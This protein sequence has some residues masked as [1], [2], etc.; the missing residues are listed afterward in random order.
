MKFFHRLRTHFRKQELDQELSEELAFHIE[1]E[2]EENIAAGMSAEEAR[3]AALRKFGGVEQVKEECRDAWG[4]RFIDTLIQDIRFGLRMLAK[5]PGFTAVAV[6]TLALGIGANTAIFT[7]VNA[8][9]LRNLPVKNP[10]QLVLFYDGVD[11]GTHNS[12]KVPDNAYSYQAWIYFRDHNESFEDLCAFRQG[13]DRLIMLGGGASEPAHR[14]EVR[15]KL[16]AGNY[17]T[18]LG[19][20]A[21]AGRLLTAQDDTPNASPGAV[22]SYDFWRRRFNLARSVI[23]K[24]VDLNGVVFTVLGVTPPEFFGERVG[25]PPDYWLPLSWQPQVLQRESW[26]A[27]QDVY[28]LN[29][30]GRLK[31]GVSI[32]SAQA[33]VNTQLHS[34]YMMQAGSRITPEQQRQIQGVHIQLRPGGRGISVLR[35]V[36][37]EPLHVLMAVVVL[38]LLIA[39]A[40]VATL[41]LGRASAR[42]SEL[43]VRS[44]L[45]AGRSRLVRQLLTESTLLALFGA[46][47]GAALAWLGVHLLVATLP[48]ASIVKTKPDLPVLAFTLAISVL[49]GVLFGLIPAVRSSKMG[50]AGGPSATLAGSMGRST[51]KPTYTLV[52]LQVALSSV[53]LVGAAL[54]THS[55]LDLEHQDLGF[56]SDN[57]LLV[58]AGFQFAG[59]PQAQ[60]L[61]L[62]QQIQV[63][64]NALPGVTAASMARFS[65]VSG[66]I[67][68]SNFSLEGYEPPAG[69]EIDVYE[70]PV[71]PRFFETLGIPI[72]LG[73][74]IGPQDTPTS[75]LVAMVNQTFTHEYL[76]GQNPIGHH[77]S[78]GAPF[79]APGAEIIGVVADSKYYNLREKPK[80]M[81]FFPLWQA[82][83]DKHVDPNAGVL[84]IRV[85]REPSGAI[86]AVRRA[87]AEIDSGL[88][89]EGVQTLHEQIYESIDQERMVTRS[90]SFF[91][92]LALTLACI[93]LYGTMTYFVARKTKEIGIRMALGAPRSRILWMFLRDSV[94]LVVLGLAVGLPLAMGATRWIRSLLFGLPAI[95]WMAIGGTVGLMVAV[96]AVAA[97]LP[98]RRATKVDPM[99]ALR[100]E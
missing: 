29:L 97:Y 85:S 37:S 92:L 89:I 88:P 32:E 91:G 62:Y 24:T 34:Y 18:V 70:L 94:A 30:M 79:K 23:G 63:R 35:F 98:A 22:I 26:L 87:L 93:G 83:A 36:Y 9:M 44:A 68:Y 56:N 61:P 66:N 42:R 100:Y 46:V 11:T 6:L 51:L 3:Y 77:I 78:I 21:A 80:P 59:V 69:K 10:S 73:R 81:A 33:T 53:L 39:C 8:V 19:V 48:L 28:W 43:F 64:L 27:S 54:L 67:S 82:G 7:I 57:V 15:G 41:M 95:D 58:R 17:F 25:M 55:L 99:V 1:Q 52:A 49:T 31:P 90:C 74:P 38:V 45:G 84:I 5:N 75:P 40:N 12:N 65:P 4:V 47:A 2:T 50:L 71:G 60:L 96:S 86:A 16:V 72:L 14:E 76:S 13:S 20:Q